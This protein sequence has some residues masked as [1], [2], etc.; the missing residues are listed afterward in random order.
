MNNK[1]ITNITNSNITDTIFNSN[2]SKIVK[3]FNSN[4]SDFEKASSHIADHHSLDTQTVEKL[5]DFLSRAEKADKTNDE[6]QRRVIKNKFW[7]FMDTLGEKTTTVLTI[8]EKFAS[9]LN[10]FGQKPN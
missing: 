5:L 9:V 7:Q 10:F 3:N 1:N 6:N 8:L 2:G 4:L